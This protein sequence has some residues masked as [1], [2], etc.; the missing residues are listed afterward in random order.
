MSYFEVS[1]Q[2]VDYDE[3]KFGEFKCH[4]C[5]RKW[6]SSKAWENF[7]QKCIKCNIVVKAIKLWPLGRYNCFE[8][9][10]SWTTKFDK[11]GLNCDQCG[12]IVWKIFLEIFFQF[13]QVLFG[14]NEIFS[15][16]LKIS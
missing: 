6:Y 1:R 14:R 5:G 2:N 7:G 4:D 11:N 13:F 8:C 10:R 9:Q 15:L 12:E 16:I 3:Q